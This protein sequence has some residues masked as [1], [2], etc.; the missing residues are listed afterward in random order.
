M[1]G[2]EALTGGLED[3]GFQ[4]YLNGNKIL[5]K[6][7]SNVISGSLLV[8]KIAAF[9]KY[10]IFFKIDFGYLLNM[11]NVETFYLQ[12]VVLLKQ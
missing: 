4:D 2:L 12:L 11:Q 1:L 7:Q 9:L 8:K 6:Y 10:C 3:F 5:I